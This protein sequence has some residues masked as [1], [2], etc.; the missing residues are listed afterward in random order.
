MT[1]GNVARLRDQVA[2]DDYIL[3]D[4]VREFRPSLGT[5]AV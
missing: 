3:N 4:L 5:V 2:V 1:F